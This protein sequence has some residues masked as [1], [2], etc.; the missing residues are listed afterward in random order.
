M[1]ERLKVLTLVAVL[2]IL[3]PY[4]LLVIV[5]K[6]RPEERVAMIAQSTTAQTTPKSQTRTI[7]VLDANGNIIDMPEDEYLVSVVLCEMPA[8]FE[9]EALKAQAVVARTYALRRQQLG[10]KHSPAA[11]CCEPSCCQGFTAVEQYLKSGGKQ[12]DIEKI[13]SAVTATKDMVI[14]FAGELIEATYFSCSGGYTEDAKAVWG[15]DIPYLRAIESPGE[16]SASRYV[17]TVSFS[18]EEFVS[19]LGCSMPDDQSKWVESVTYTSGGGVASVRL[20]GKIFTGTTVRQLLGLRSTAFTI[21]VVGDRVTITT[22]GFG[23]RVGMS[24]YGADAMAANDSTY[25]DILRHYYQGVEI[26]RF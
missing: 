12:K 4:L 11:V 14:T 15:A 2:G 23:H 25:E 22:K 7:S 17:D 8:E 6:L 24:Q 5:D 1:K 21:A 18:K 9:I 3:C 26:T 20:C 10:S 13:E 19:K 16:E